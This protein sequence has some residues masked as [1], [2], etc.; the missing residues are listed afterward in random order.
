MLM[1]GS[2]LGWQRVSVC[3]RPRQYSI[4]VEGV[5]LLHAIVRFVQL[6]HIL[7]FRCSV[8]AGQCCCCWCCSRASYL[9]MQSSHR[10]VLFGDPDI[11]IKKNKEKK[12]NKQIRV[13]F[14]RS[15]QFFFFLYFNL[16]VMFRQATVMR[17]RLSY[18]YSSLK[19]AASVRVTRSHGQA[20]IEMKTA[21]GTAQF[22]FA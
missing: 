13:E 5:V 20:R 3:A 6:W 7:R 21:N 9:R 17:T 10:N 22:T 8:A 2:K 11:A 12:T 18:G 16:F 4:I 1:F 15:F 14:S 19:F